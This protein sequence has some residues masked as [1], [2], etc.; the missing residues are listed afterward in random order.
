MPLPLPSFTSGPNLVAKS[1]LPGGRQE[2]I[3]GPRPDATVCDYPGSPAEGARAVTDGYGCA[4]LKRAEEK[5]STET[6]P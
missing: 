1:E 3:T 2:G 4:E 5:E 6:R